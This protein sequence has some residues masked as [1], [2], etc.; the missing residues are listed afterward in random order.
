MFLNIIATA[1]LRS[2]GFGGTKSPIKGESAR[3][4]PYRAGEIFFFD[5]ITPNERSDAT[6]VKSKISSHLVLS[7]KN[8]SKTKFKESILALKTYY[9][10]GVVSI[11]IFSHERLGR[12]SLKTSYFVENSSGCKLILYICQ[13]DGILD[14][15]LVQYMI[16]Q[17]FF[18]QT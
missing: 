4:P 16:S 8:A 10:E 13:N 5:F 3:G 12:L 6:I 14:F 17:F 15:S 11:L 18:Y 9:L 2:G 7:M 1:S